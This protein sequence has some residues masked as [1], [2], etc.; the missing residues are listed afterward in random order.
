LLVSGGYLPAGYA[1]RSRIFGELTRI[2]CD[3]LGR[4]PDRNT[5]NDRVPRP[6]GHTLDTPEWLRGAL[7]VKA[8]LGRPGPIVAPEGLSA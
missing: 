1:G 2:P 8:H 4:G 6:A 7:G 3:P 5:G